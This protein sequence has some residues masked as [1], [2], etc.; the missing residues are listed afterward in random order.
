MTALIQSERGICCRGGEALSLFPGNELILSAMYHKYGAAKL[1]H[2]REI[3][4][5]IAQQESW[6]PIARCENVQ[7]GKCRFQY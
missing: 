7:G 2:R 5:V 1:R 6:S 3:V 4:E